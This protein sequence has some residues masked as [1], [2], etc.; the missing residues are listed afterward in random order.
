MD[1]VDADAIN[2]GSTERT[3]PR[4]HDAVNVLAI[5]AQTSRAIS[6]RVTVASWRTKSF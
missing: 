4:L 3:L 2:M 6:H 5:E 1:L